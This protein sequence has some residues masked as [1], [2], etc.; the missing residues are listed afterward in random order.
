MYYKK[1]SS[2]AL[3]RC[4]AQEAE[5]QQ[6]NKM[7]V[8]HTVVSFLRV[9]TPLSHNRKYVRIMW[10]YFTELCIEY[11]I[12][13]GFCKY[14]RR[15]SDWK[16]AHI[17]EKIPIKEI[18]ALQSTWLQIWFW[19]LKPTHHHYLFYHLYLSGSYDININ[20]ITVP[21]SLQWLIACYLNGATCPLSVQLVLI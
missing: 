9:L 18:P 4:S 13:L 14:W 8:V 17:V 20:D 11:S 2:D 19:L 15:M 6:N 5:I 12:K 10:K 16:H 7:N 3:L 21:T 1:V